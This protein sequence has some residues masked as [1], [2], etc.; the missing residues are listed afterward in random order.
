[1]YV[2][3]NVHIRETEKVVL[4]WN[5]LGVCVGEGGVVF[6]E[7]ACDCRSW[8]VQ[9]SQGSQAYWMMFWSSVRRQS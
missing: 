5:A 4:V 1:M 9:N 3:M 6:K 2:C 7:L 8:Q